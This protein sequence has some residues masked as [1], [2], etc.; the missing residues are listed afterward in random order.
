MPATPGSPLEGMTRLVID[1]TNLLFRLGGG[2]VAAPPG[3]IIGKLRAI[4]P[5]TVAIDLVFDGVGHGVTGRLANGMHVRY[6]GRR[7]ADHAILELA[8]EAATAAGVRVATGAGVLVVTDD[9][10]LRFR[11]TTRGVR[12]V[13]LM[14]LIDRLGR[15]TLVSPSVGNRRRTLGGS[16]P[17][18]EIGA[19]PGGGPGGDPGAG[20]GGGGADPGATEEPE[21]RR[22][23]PGRGATAKTGPAH[24][25]ARHKR[26]PRQP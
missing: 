9:R 14:W 10:E 2:S 5:A 13:P 16:R 3:A 1:G 23:T 17:A 7:S 6:S 26:H 11:L 18:T 24:K 8:D 19:G 12:T 4:I 15:S 25:I 20:G 22:W 21:R